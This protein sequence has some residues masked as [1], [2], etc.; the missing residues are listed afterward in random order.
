MAI[1]NKSE[2]WWLRLT[3]V[4]IVVGLLSLLAVENRRVG[5]ISKSHQNEIDSLVKINDS[6]STDLFK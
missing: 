5:E 2:N 3:I 1:L 6:I 4:L